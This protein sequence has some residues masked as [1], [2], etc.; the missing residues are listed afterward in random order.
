M[1]M[2]PANRRSSFLQISPSKRLRQALP[3]HRHPSLS[4]SPFLA[5]PEPSHPLKRVRRQRPYLWPPILCKPSL[6]TTLRFSPS[7]F[8][9]CRLPLTLLGLCCLPPSSKMRPPRTQM[10]VHLML[11]LTPRTRA[12]RS[13]P[14]FSFSAL[15]SFPWRPSLPSSAI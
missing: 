2:R 15:F 7:S 4:S 8:H 10:S 11:R 13:S 1:E 12:G 5:I 6:S 9:S 3:Y 14:H